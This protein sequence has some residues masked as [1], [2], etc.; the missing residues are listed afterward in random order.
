MKK[1]ITGKYMLKNLSNFKK[2]SKL[3]I[4][5]T[6]EKSKKKLVWNI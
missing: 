5:W 4:I 1:G 6:E 3:S 2:K